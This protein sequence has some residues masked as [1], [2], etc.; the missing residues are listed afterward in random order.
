MVSA[1]LGLQRWR[2]RN[3]MVVNQLEADLY[4]HYDLE[5]GISYDCSQLPAD[6][7]TA[8]HLLLPSYSPLAEHW[9]SA[10][11]AVRGQLSNCTKT[12]GAFVADAALLDDVV[13]EIQD[14]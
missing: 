7:S 3:F 8:S 6:L 12:S 5:P 10:L 2:A 9:A 13:F 1:D 4:P 11:G 14:S